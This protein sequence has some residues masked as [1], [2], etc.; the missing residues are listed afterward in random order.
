MLPSARCMRALPLFFLVACSSA[1]VLPDGGPADASIDASIEAGTQS[2]AVAP[3]TTRI[4]YGAAWI[5]GA[6]HPD[7][8][9]VAS[10]PV[11]WDGTCTDDGTNSYATLSNGWKPYFS[12]HSACVIAFDESA[13]CGAGTCATRVAYGA[14]WMA[15]ANHPAS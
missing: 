15:P 14:G 8:F 12:G 13:S 3:C 1:A 7:D 4:Q 10:G 11:T 2:D 9:D 5:H 6:N